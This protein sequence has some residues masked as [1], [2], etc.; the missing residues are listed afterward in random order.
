[1]RHFYFGGMAK[2]VGFLYETEYDHGFLHP[3]IVL[4][5]DF[6]ELGIQRFQNDIKTFPDSVKERIIYTLKQRIIA[7][8]KVDWTLQQAIEQVLP[9]SLWHLNQES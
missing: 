7:F 5:A 8:R 1:M 6:C 2:D 3:N 4:P 9:H